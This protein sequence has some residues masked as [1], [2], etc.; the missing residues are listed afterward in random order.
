MMKVDLRALAPD[1]S[2]EALKASDPYLKTYASIQHGIESYCST[3]DNV[4][5]A[6]G[7]RH[8]KSE[9]LYAHSQRYRTVYLMHRSILLALEELKPH[10]N[11]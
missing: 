6:D 5:Q 2:N 9:L 11:T 4:T 8:V 10:E 3:N 7:W 1:I